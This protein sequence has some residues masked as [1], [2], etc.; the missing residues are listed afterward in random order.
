MP[1]YARNDTPVYR[2]IAVATSKNSTGRF[3]LGLL[4]NGKRVPG[5]KRVL[6]K[7]TDLNRFG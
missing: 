2:S 4:D 1:P 3:W 6:K 7:A 5:L